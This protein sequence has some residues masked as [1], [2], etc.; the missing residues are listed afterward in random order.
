MKNLLSKIIFLS[1]FIALFISCSSSDSPAPTPVDTKPTISSFSPQS[2]ELGSTIT[3]TGTNFSTTAANNVVTI[4]GVPATV[5]AATAIQ[6]SVTVP[7]CTGTGDVKVT[8]GSTT[9]TATSQF[10]F[11]P[12]ITF[13]KTDKI[14]TAPFRPITNTWWAI[15]EPVNFVNGNGTPS[16]FYIH[17]N[18][19]DNVN[20]GC[21]FYSIPDNRFI[22][23]GF[24]KNIVAAGNTNNLISGFGRIL[25]VGND[26]NHFA[27]YKNALT[28]ITTFLWQLYEPGGANPFPQ[29]ISTNHGESKGCIKELG[30]KLFFIGGREFCKTVKYWDWSDLTWNFAANYPITIKNGPE[31]VTDGSNLYTLGG[32]EGGTSLSNKFFKYNVRSNTWTSLADAPVPPTQSVTRSSM[33]Y[34]NKCVI[35]LGSDKLLHIF[36]TETNKWQTNTI[37]PDIPVDETGYQS[38]HIE[39]GVKAFYIL[40]RTANGMLGLQEYK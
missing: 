19:N 32:Y 8:V 27:G 11:V 12:E 15:M 13:T 26:F 18:S 40:Y 25:Y 33:V 24:S 10:T 36:N 23:T 17:N 7:V 28:G 6:I 34:F 2:S 30:N 29:S 21:V 14:V 39:D 37:N 38:V 9:V 22:D 3:I 5:T 20:K 4:N 16:G 31:I 1:A 35:Y